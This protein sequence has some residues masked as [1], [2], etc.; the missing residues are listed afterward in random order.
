M[1]AMTHT[2]TIRVLVADDHP[3]V[4]GG[5]TALLATLADI[6]VV[7]EAADGAAAVREALLTR[8]DV[9]ILD[10]RMPQLDGVRAAERIAAD[11]PGTAVLVL[12]M[13]DEDELVSDAIAAGARGYLL[14]GA[15]PEEIE[16]AVRTVAAGSAILSPQV[17]SRVLGRAVRPRPTE[18]FPQLT[19][20]EREVLDLIARGIS[21]SAIGERLGIAAKTVGNHVSAI[22]F[23][24]G[25]ATR[26]EAIVLARGAG[27]GT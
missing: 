14:K 7:G 27:L 1:I 22:F 2:A 18:S 6:E 20:R 24:L 8:P 15:Q 5:L 9:V 17:V 23:K 19:T 13:Y 11:L 21:N 3:V 16:R 10:L 26:A 4:R 12:T 25:V